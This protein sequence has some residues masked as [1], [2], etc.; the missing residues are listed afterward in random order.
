MKLLKSPAPQ[1]PS[2]GVE[3]GPGPCR[4]N[5][6]PLTA[7]QAKS[8]PSAPHGGG[9]GGC[10]FRAK[11][12]TAPACTSCKLISAGTLRM[13]HGRTETL[14][15]TVLCRRS[16]AG[17]GGRGQDTHS[18]TAENRQ[19]VKGFQRPECESG[20]VSAEPPH[21]WPIRLCQTSLTPVITGPPRPDGTTAAAVRAANTPPRWSSFDVEVSE[22]IPEERVLHR[23]EHHLDVIGVRGACEVGVERLVALLVLLPVQLQDER[24][25]R[26]GI[27]AGPCRCG[28]WGGAQ[29]PLVL[30]LGPVLRENLA[31]T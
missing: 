27:S 4:S 18:Q 26:F 11:V 31:V 13:M 14:Y 22:V 8:R 30:R 17:S 19:L 9:G 16:E 20:Q 5:L 21:S 2:P 24:F 10:L 28:G 1:L 12:V 23:A 29:R 25:G 6:F 3:P 15:Y 7:V